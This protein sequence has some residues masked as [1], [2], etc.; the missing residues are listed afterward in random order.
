MTAPTTAEW[1]SPRV[2]PASC[3]AT[4]GMAVPVGGRVVVQAAAAS[5]C[6]APASAPL[7]GGG[8]KPW[9]RTVPTPSNGQ[10]SPWLPDPKRTSMS[11]GA[12][13]PRAA[14]WA[15]KHQERYARKISPLT[16][17]SDRSGVPAP[18]WYVGLR[19]AH[20]VD[21]ATKEAG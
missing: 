4:V 21:S 11:P 3:S 14:I 2:C 8:G 1:S 19:F 17:A 15:I 9:A 10:E 20:L 5:K 12:P 18:R 13:P 16:V 6:R 7:L